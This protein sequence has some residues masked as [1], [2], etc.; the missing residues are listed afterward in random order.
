MSFPE[1][2]SQHDARIARDEFFGRPPLNGPVLPTKVSAIRESNQQVKAREARNNFFE[3]KPLRPSS[4]EETAKQQASEA[5]RTI[6]HP[7]TGG[8]TKNEGLGGTLIIQDCDG[9]E[10]LRIPKLMGLDG[11]HTIQTGCD[12]ASSYPV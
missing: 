9:N 8:K 4:V 6:H 5:T 11:E 2:P 1:S 10:L 12:G 3:P 7:V